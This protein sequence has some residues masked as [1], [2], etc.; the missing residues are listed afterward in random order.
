M[1]WKHV[2]LHSFFFMAIRV[3]QFQTLRLRQLGDTKTTGL[4]QVCFLRKTML[5]ISISKTHLFT[6][7]LNT[8]LWKNRKT[9]LSEG[10]FN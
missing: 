7:K 2:A 9:M 1:I 5:K 6:F 8:S 3:K 4:N 10:N